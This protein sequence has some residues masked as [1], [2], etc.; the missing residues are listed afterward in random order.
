MI[1]VLCHIGHLPHE[2]LNEL[3]IAL[4]PKGQAQAHFVTSQGSSVSYEAGLWLASHHG[5]T[6][7]LHWLSSP[8]RGASQ[9]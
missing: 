2:P 3:Q 9:N 6:D 4:D 1:C 7:F 8:G 5:K